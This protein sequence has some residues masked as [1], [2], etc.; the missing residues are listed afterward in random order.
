VVSGL[1]GGW[2]YNTF[3]VRFNVAN[4]KVLSNSRM[5]RINRRLNCFGFCDFTLKNDHINYNLHLVL[6]AS[7]KTFNPLIRTYFHCYFQYMKYDAYVLAQSRGR[8]VYIDINR[9]FPYH[10]GIVFDNDLAH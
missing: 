4:T 10:F 1:S 5:C 7:D 8:V 6:S 3:F 2:W 9:G